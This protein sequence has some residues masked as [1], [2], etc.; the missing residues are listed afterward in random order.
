MWTS[1]LH[2]CIHT[3][4]IFADHTWKNIA[5]AVLDVFDNWQLSTDKLVATSGSNTVVAFS[6]LSL[7]RI[8]CFSL[9]LDL[10]NRNSLNVTQIRVLGRCHYLV[11][12]F[13]CS[14]KNN[15]DLR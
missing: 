12:L 8:S 3:V 7:W 6:N 9:N 10:A 4:L 5:G 13:H 14:W 2:D 11:E 15:R 1:A